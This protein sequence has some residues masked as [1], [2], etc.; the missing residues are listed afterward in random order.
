MAVLPAEVLI[1]GLLLSP[2]HSLVCVYP[3]LAGVLAKQREHQGTY[4]GSV[5]PAVHV[6]PGWLP[7]SWVGLRL[8]M[9]MYSSGGPLT[10]QFQTEFLFKRASPF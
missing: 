5:L 7:I 9:S 2:L 8:D 4:A 6:Q 1:L 3:G 10:A